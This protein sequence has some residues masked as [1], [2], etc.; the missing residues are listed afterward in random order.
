MD[1]YLFKLDE[2]TPALQCE[3]DRATIDI[4]KTLPGRR[5]VPEASLWTVPYTLAI[6]ERLLKEFQGRLRIEDRLCDECYLFQKK[7]DS[8]REP[9]EKQLRQQ[10]QIRG[11]SV[12]TIQAYS[13]HVGRYLDDYDT[14]PKLNRQECLQKYMLALLDKKLSHAYVNQA[15]SAIKF[16]EQKVLQ[17][18]N[19]VPYVR[20][21][22]RKQASK[23]PCAKRSESAARRF[24][25]SGASSAIISCLL[26]GLARWRSRATPDTGL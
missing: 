3:F 15:I 24:V 13:G 6:A 18:E 1:V 20:P 17:I 7:R 2:K 21:K 5:W 11:Y 26:F 12:K 22:K 9:Y 14:V 25:Q 16:Y 10:L 8:R 23:C 19:A 4:I